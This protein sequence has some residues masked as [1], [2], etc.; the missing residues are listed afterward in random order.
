MV[1]VSAGVVVLLFLESELEE[2]VLFL[3]VSS[4]GAS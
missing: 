3:V 2:S 4:S 1:A